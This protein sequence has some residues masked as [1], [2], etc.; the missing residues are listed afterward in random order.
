MKTTVF[1][2]IV[3]VAVA[4]IAWRRQMKPARCLGVIDA[5]V[6]AFNEEVC[7]AVAIDRLMRNPYF[8]RVIVVNDGSTDNTRQV[9]D[10]IAPLHPRL[11]VIHQEN[12]GKGGALMAGIAKSD[13]PFVF[14]TDADTI[15]P[16][17]GDGLGFM[18]AE[19]ARGADAVGGIPLS[20]LEGA[21]LLPQI[22][23]STKLVVIAVQRTFQQLTGGSPFLISG[24]CGL[25]R[26]EVL[27]K[28][29]FSDRTKVE[30]L[31]LTWS[32]ITQGYRVRQSSRSFVYSQEANSL[33]AE[34]R[35]WRRWIAG[36]AVCMR[37]HRKLLLTRFGLL[38]IIPVALSSFIA[39][40]F[41]AHAL[42]PM[43][44][45]GDLLHLPL[46]LFP[47]Q[48]IAI[49]FMIGAVGAIHHRRPWLI[50]LAPAALVYVVMSY[51]VWLLHGLRGLFTG[52][53]P[54]RDKPE[55]YAHVVG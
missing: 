14:L 25:F 50:L 41:M 35:R 42:W 38:T 21:G 23:A 27:L 30:D 29:P 43:L 2:C 34:W 5:I 53:E 4:W 24:A 37:L 33:V 26:R 13:K 52:L 18:L 3:F 45:R 48:W 28:V 44:S 9:L 31:D 55:R 8:N 12:T 47:W 39:F 36:Y 6:P 54:S 51:M 49:I 46:A 40:G 19:M 32:L 1:F 10:D 17:S 7:I 11:T 15:V 20:D 16:E 22:R